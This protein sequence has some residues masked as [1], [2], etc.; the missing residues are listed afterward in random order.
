M[1]LAEAALFI[2]DF[3]V[4]RGP[5]CHSTLPGSPTL[6]ELDCRDPVLILIYGSQFA[7]DGP[8]FLQGFQPKCRCWN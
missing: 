3:G 5:L 7:P 1:T 4:A 2:N 6:Y 8:I